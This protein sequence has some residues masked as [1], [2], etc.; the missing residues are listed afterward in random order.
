[1]PAA[2]TYSIPGTT[3]GNREDLDG[4]LRVIA[5]E[6][7]PLLSM[8]PRGP[9]PTAMYTEWMVDNLDDARLE[10][11]PENHSVTTFDNKAVDQAR[12][13]NYVMHPKP[14]TWAVTREQMLI[15]NAAHDDLAAAAR[16]RVAKE[17][18]KD[19]EFYICSGADRVQMT[20]TTAGVSRGFFDWIDSAG[21]SDVPSAYR[22][23]S[24]QIV[25]NSDT[26]TNLTEAQLSG[27]IKAFWDTGVPT[28]NLTLFGGSGIVQQI[29]TFT[30][31]NSSSTAT[32]YTINAPDNGKITMMCQRFETSLGML[33][34]GP[35]RH[36]N[37]T[38][39]TRTLN[40]ALILSPDIYDICYLDPL[41]NTED[42]VTD[43]SGPRGFVDA[44]FTLRVK[45]PKG[46]GKIV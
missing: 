12:L 21:P 44:E 5:V 43:G 31:T 17:Y 25:N 26:A 22:T 7:T 40:A 15:D 38:A 24:G 39:G 18:K 27:L 13:G 9:K 1:M 46:L 42:H 37:P 20:G 34:V 19:I 32:R 33:T 41:G 29:D 35:A 3:G 4:L 36:L 11:V 16:R 2:N 23:P 28:E 14:R 6:E 45:N 10:A 8:A 30:R